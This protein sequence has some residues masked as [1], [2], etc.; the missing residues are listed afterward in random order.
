VYTDDPLPT[1]GPAF[2]YNRGGNIVLVVHEPS[3]H[4]DPKWVTDYVTGVVDANVRAHGRGI[5]LAV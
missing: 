1:S 3:L 5:A 2:I 4:E